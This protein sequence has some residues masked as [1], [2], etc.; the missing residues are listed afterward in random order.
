MY[1]NAV[2]K[3]YFQSSLAEVGH[4]P[5]DLLVSWCPLGGLWPS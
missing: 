3:I 1:L 2:A 5:G 4:W